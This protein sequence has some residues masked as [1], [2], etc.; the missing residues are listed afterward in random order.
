MAVH[1]QAQVLLDLMY[2]TGLGKMHDAEPEEVRA[3]MANLRVPSQEHVAHVEDRAIPGPAGSIPVRVYRPSDEPGLPVLVYF[4]GGAWVIGDIESHDGITRALANAVPCIVVSVDYRL[5]PEHKFPAAVDDAVAATAWVHEHARDLGADATRVAVG[6]DSAGANLA[7][8]TALVA[9][10]HDGPPLVF[11]LLVYPVTDHDFD[12]PSVRENAEGYFFEVGGMRWMYAHYLQDES[13]A[14]DWRVSPLRA[15]SH[16]GLPPAFVLTAE[17][18]P[19]RD[20]GEAY[21]RKLDAAGVSVEARRYEGVFHGF[22]GMQ[23]FIE[24]AKDA[25][26]DAVGAL[27]SAFAE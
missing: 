11:Q 17:L 20:Q 15:A 13:D 14:A 12:S 26:D 5:A 18:D 19:L 4:H 21:G 8:V 27:R 24:P 10:D 1:P 25:F 22:F 6:G 3:L 16:A 23:Q 2:A 7:T 9:R